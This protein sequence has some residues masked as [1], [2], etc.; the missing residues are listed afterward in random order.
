[1]ARRKVDQHAEASG[2]CAER[3]ERSC[4]DEEGQQPTGHDG[5]IHRLMKYSRRETP[6]SAAIGRKA[7][8]L[9]QM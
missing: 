4:G 3:L 2:A 9:A 8:A 6:S 7:Q 1:M 5:R